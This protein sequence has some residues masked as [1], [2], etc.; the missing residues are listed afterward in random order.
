MRRMYNQPGGQVLLAILHII[1]MYIYF[2]RKSHSR[3]KKDDM[4]IIFIV[5]SE[6]M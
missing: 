6:V 1:D 4:M 5:K 2:V 3:G